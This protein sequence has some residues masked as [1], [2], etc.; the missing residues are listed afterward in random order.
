MNR[1]IGRVVSIRA[2]NVMSHFT[3][4]TFL[5]VICVCM[6]QLVWE[7]ATEVDSNRE[8]LVIHAA[9]LV[10]NVTAVVLAHVVAKVV[11]D[12]P[13]LPL[14]VALARIKELLDLSWH[15][16]LRLMKMVGFMGRKIQH[17]L[18]QSS[19][20]VEFWT[21]KRNRAVLRLCQLI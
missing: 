3:D 5:P 6:N 17:Q 18:Q 7:Q 12:V 13:L 2:Y 8:Q 4:K 11:L 21:M 9:M 19:H 20:Q 16:T 1:V 14:E 15:Q 10:P